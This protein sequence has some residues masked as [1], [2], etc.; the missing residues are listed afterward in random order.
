LREAAETEG[1]IERSEEKG[2]GQRKKARSRRGV[3][4]VE[5]RR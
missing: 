1:D 2:M 3:S 4:I 5:K